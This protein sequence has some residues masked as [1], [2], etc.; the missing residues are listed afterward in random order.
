MT[1]VSEKA[2]NSREEYFSVL[3]DI[4]EKNYESYEMYGKWKRPHI[5]NYLI[6]RNE[7]FDIK[8]VKENGYKILETEDR[9]F[10]RIKNNESENFGF[11]ETERD[12]RIWRFS[13][14]APSYYSDSFVEKW[15]TSTRYLDRS[16]FINSTLATLEKR[17]IFRGIGLDFYDSLGDAAE[18]NRFSLKMWTSGELE[19]YQDKILQL[20][21]D[22]F[23]RRS[24]RLQEM[25]EERSKHL[26][27]VYSNGKVTTTFAKNP[28]Y[29]MNILS[30]LIT[31]YKK[32][33]ELIEENRGIWGGLIEI[34]LS[35][36][37]PESKLDSLLSFFRK[38]QN[39]FRLWMTEL[40]KT[41]KIHRIYGVDL[42]TGQKIGLDITKDSIWIN[43]GSGKD[44]CGN[45]ALRISSLL[46]S[47][48]LG[49][50]E[51]YVGGVLVV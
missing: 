32:S 11:L 7:Q 39:P 47:Y 19:E 20:L 42:H 41:E 13:S 24:L 34:R 35:E 27:E 36:P 8:K 30:D 37:I 44:D 1:S 33:L 3:E 29:I 49:S 22:K 25:E 46:N 21:K 45:A 12:E 14:F 28:T 40:E 17:Y 50:A 26:F 2:I 51:L 6:E 38:G 31:R 15:V 4:L 18:R 43:M 10:F 48:V 16:W 23:S 5:K 9:G